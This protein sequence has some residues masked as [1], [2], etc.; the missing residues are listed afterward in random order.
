MPDY[1]ITCTMCR[2]PFVFTEGEQAWFAE[3]DYTPPRRCRPCRA[4]RKA[5]TQQA[6][7]MRQENKR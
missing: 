5:G 4:E 1:T 3:R 2:T 6:L 7:Q